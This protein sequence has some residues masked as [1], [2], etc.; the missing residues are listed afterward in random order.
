MAQFP[1][2]ALASFYGILTIEKVFQVLNAFLQARKIIAGGYD[3]LKTSI[4]PNT[5]YTVTS[6]SGA[7][8]L[9]GYGSQLHRMMLYHEKGAGGQIPVTAFPLATAIGGAAQ[10]Q[11][12]TF[13]TNAT[14]SGSY[15]FRVGSYLVE[16]VIQI[17]VSAGN[18]PDEIAALLN[19]AINSNPNL[20]FTST[21]ALGVVTCVAKT[22]DITSDKLLITAN[23]KEADLLPDAMEVNIVKSSA[24]T[25]KSDLAG[26]Y[27][28]VS[29]ESS[30]WNTTFI[31]PYAD[32][33]TLDG[34]SNTIG[35]PNDQS[36]LYDPRDYRPA[37][38]YTVDTAPGEAGLAAAITLADGR[39]L[40]CANIRI[41]AP[42]YPE[43]GYEIASY[44]T[45]RME[46]SAMAQS[47]R[48]Y[49]HLSLTELYGPLDITNDWTSYKENGKSYDNRDLAR[50]A[51]LTVITF[52]D[53]VS[54]IGDVAGFW[55]PDDNNNKPFTM[56]V[57]RWKSWSIQNLYDLYVNGD[58]QK[59]RAIVTNAGATLQSENAID[60]DIL[61]AGLDQVSSLLGT[62]AWLYDAAFTI[63]NTEVIPS[64]SNPDRF[65]FKLPCVL[66]GNNRINLGEV[67][68]DN[69]P[70]V[71]TLTIVQS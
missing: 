31:V 15:I 19:T 16:D 13:T 22:E 61:K 45:G 59:G 46:A 60:E 65:D 24:G 12:I 5:P 63:R 66:S 4:A 10:E 41:E 2:N 38:C 23:Q 11:T 17:G 29:A 18:T 34:I 64:D 70:N 57:N 25:G 48:A 62:N 30:P 67:G 37:S 71:V 1:N 54:K 53:N 35:Q 43:L 42:D 51:G 3:P 26:F 47:S 28:Y 69:N 8:K 7:A 44:F 49:T 36:G 68:I 40:D 56:Q 21:V 39:E 6:A 52:L 9:F 14:S 27:S 32:E 20:P 50:Q 58:E 33:I 55:S